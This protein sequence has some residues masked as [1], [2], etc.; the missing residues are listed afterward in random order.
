MGYNRYLLQMITL[1]QRQHAGHF[2]LT[3]RP[4]SDR[5]RHTKS[6]QSATFTEHLPGFRCG[7]RSPQM[8]STPYVPSDSGTKPVVPDAA[9]QV[10]EC[11]I[12]PKQCQRSARWLQT[13]SLLPWTGICHTT[14]S[15]DTGLMD[16]IKRT[17]T[18]LA[19][20]DAKLHSLKL[21]PNEANQSTR[22]SFEKSLCMQNALI[23]WN[24]FSPV[25]TNPTAYLK[26]TPPSGSHS[27][28]PSK[29]INALHF[30]S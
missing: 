18:K 28:S 23:I 27:W 5:E 19:W 29:F 17:P 6:W 9:S 12:T 11:W 21:P 4:S 3:D 14:V 7:C 1:D 30:T 13:R 10:T 8:I 16:Q 20:P 24:I 25:T 26:W 22:R 15:A 2:S